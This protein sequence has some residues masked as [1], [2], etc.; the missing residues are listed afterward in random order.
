MSEQPLKP[1]A[2]ETQQAN[3]DAQVVTAPRDLSAYPLRLFAHQMAEIYGV[4]LSRIYA[5]DAEGFFLFAEIKPR[6]GRK[7]WDRER[8]RQH[9]AGE[10][11]GLTVSR[12]RA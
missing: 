1:S 4:S 5:L 2:P 7:S 11:R 6:V 10:L 9:F 8:I 12:K 3:S